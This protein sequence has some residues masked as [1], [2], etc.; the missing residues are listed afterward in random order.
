MQ[1]ILIDRGQL[2]D[3]RFV[4]IFDD[5]WVALHFLFLLSALIA[6]MACS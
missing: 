1:P 2:A 6:I 3:E 5:P 4:E